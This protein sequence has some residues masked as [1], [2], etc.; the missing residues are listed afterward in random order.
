MLAQQHPELQPAVQQL[1]ELSDTP[2]VR[3]VYEAR[4]KFLRDERARLK[5]ARQEGLAKGRAEGIDEG[6]AIGD[7]KARR[8]MVESLLALGAPIAMLVKASGFTEAEV[9]A[10]QRNMPKH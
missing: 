6:L 1:Y 2:E 9:L 3:A 4:E 7:A 5:G 10:I 8:A